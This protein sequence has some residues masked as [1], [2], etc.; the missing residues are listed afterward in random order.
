[1]ALAISKVKFGM[2]F[3]VEGT[4]GT[5]LGNSSYTL[6]ITYN[7]TLTGGGGA[8]Q[9]TKVYSASRTIAASGSENLD[10]AAS[11]TD[12]FGAS[13][14]F[15]SVKFILFIAD[16]A[17]VNDVVI[18]AAASAQFQGPLGDVDQTIQVSPGEIF[19]ITKRAATGWPVTATTADLLMVANSG[20]TTGVTYRVVLL[21]D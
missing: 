6:P 21:G 8:D 11:L 16:P 4:G 15:A 13:I 10:L 9:V 1:M 20:G 5:G 2:T 3:S 12:D 19:L 17:N 7:F 14:T 18:G